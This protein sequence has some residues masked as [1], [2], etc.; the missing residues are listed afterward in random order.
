MN[1]ICTTSTTIRRVLAG[2]A[3][4]AMISLPTACGQQATPGA[5]SGPATNA[6]AQTT[7]PQT[8]DAQ[9]SPTESVFDGSHP[10]APTASPSESVFDG[11]HPEA[12]TA[13]PSESVFDGSHPEAP[14]QSP[15][16]T[17]VDGSH[18][19]PIMLGESGK[20]T[21]THFTVE[22][23]PITREGTGEHANFQVEVCLVRPANPEPDGSTR[24]SVD[25]W[26]LDNSTELGIKARPSTE[27]TPAF[28]A[29]ARLTVG[30][31]ARGWIEFEDDPAAHSVALSYR[32]SL[33]EH[34][35]WSFGQ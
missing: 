24:V 11:S 13:S 20:A 14:T 33:G 22:L 17:S 6:P 28:P 4:L 34:A 12:P 15:A 30:E 1:A 19:E 5:T 16:A 25:P 31:C 8:Q 29:V 18:P 21:F 23:K 3:G 9:T 35:I 10:D 2:L 7:A 32:N 27:F 26:T